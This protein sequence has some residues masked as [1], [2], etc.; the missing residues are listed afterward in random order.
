MILDLMDTSE[1]TAY[2]KGACSASLKSVFYCSEFTSVITDVNPIEFSAVS[3]LT[4]GDLI[5]DVAERTSVAILEM[6]SSTHYAEQYC[7]IYYRIVLE[8]PS[9][10]F[11][12]DKRF[13]AVP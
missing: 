4:S 5:F 6:S 7:S 2:G 8:C 12:F 9:I 3:D 11:F 1:C 13:K 10:A